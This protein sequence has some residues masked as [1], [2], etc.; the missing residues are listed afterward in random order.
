MSESMNSEGQI[1]IKAGSIPNPVP[2]P[3]WAFKNRLTSSALVE[4]DYTYVT[5]PFLTL[6]SGV[7]LTLQSNAWLVIVG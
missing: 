7:V 1:L 4:T 6:E 3:T 5:G 2:V